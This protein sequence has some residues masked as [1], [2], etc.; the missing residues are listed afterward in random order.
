LQQ[1]RVLAAT[2][3]DAH[4]YGHHNKPD[5]GRNKY[6]APRPLWGSCAAA[7]ADELSYE[8]GV[9]LAYMPGD[10]PRTSTQL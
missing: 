10:M 7:A 2:C 1:R 4:A 6:T 3:H 9:L 5:R 8:E